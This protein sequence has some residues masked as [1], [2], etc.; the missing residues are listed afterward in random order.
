MTNKFSTFV[1]HNPCDKSVVP[2]KNSVNPVIFSRDL[3]TPD[4]TELR[5]S[6]SIKSVLYPARAKAQAILVEVVDFPSPGFT[7]VIE[8]T[9]KL[10]P[11]NCILVRSA[12]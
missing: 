4:M 6:A 11:L 1:S 2:D 5:I 12:L 9:F 10:F 8:I 7:D 3:K